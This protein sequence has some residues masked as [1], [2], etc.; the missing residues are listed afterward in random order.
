MHSDS[1]KRLYGNVRQP[2][3]T[4]ADEFR[5][6]TLTRSPDSNVLL[7]VHAEQDEN[8]IRT[9]SARRAKKIEE[10]QYFQGD[11]YER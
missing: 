4:G 9:I 3:D 5:F 11:Y 7:I 2:I 6:R 10:E 1:K 8:T